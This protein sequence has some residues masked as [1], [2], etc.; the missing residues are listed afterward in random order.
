MKPVDSEG[1]TQHPGGPVPRGAKV[2][3]T[4]RAKKGKDG[5]VPPEHA[6]LHTAPPIPHGLTSSHLLGVAEALHGGQHGNPGV[7]KR[8]ARFPW[9]GTWNLGTLSTS[10][11]GHSLSLGPHPL[12]S[13]AGPAHREE[14]GGGRVKAE[15]GSGGA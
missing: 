12:V 1:Q 8:K 15:E 4:G 13:T 10:P 9:G 6:I 14:G 7:R 5:Q 2:H 11:K 3:P